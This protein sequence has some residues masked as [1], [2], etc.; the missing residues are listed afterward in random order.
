MHNA[1]TQKN[2]PKKKTPEQPTNQPK[3][4]K[5]TTNE[6]QPF[7]KF[8]FIILHTK[9]FSPHLLG[10]L[11]ISVMYSDV[12]ISLTLQI[13]YEQVT[14]GSCHGIC[15]TCCHFARLWQTV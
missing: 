6:L 1:S 3:K 2:A 7:I 14:Q 12:N 5:E 15:A 4:K 8:I 11:Q 13:K 9:L 10:S